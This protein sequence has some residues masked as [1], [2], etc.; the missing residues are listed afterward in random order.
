MSRRLLAAVLILLVELCLP[1]RPALARCVLARLA[2]LPVSLKH[3]RP[4][5]SLSL[6]GRET[7]FLIWND[8]FYSLLPPE[9]ASELKLRLDQPQDQFFV[10]GII[11]P[12]S[13]RMATVKTVGVGGLTIRNAQFLVRTVDSGK[14]GGLGQNF[15]DTGDG[16]EYDFGHGMLRLWRER[17]CGPDAHP[18]WARAGEPYSV[19]HLDQNSLRSGMWWDSRP[20]RRT[21]AFVNGTR[22]RVLIDTGSPVSLL[23]PLAAREAGVSLEGSAVTRGGAAPEVG[24]DRTWIAPFASFKIGDEELHDV[25]LRLGD[26][27]EYGVEM[28]LGADFFHSHRIYEVNRE[29]QLYFTY[30]GGNPVNID[31]RP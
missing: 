28:L 18:Y 11:D 27:K 9:V 7:P 13:W 21:I 2:E 17:D 3:G 1:D 29:H 16:I 23:S 6:E 5:V 20:F 4:V 22:I 15:L 10:R 30:N 31:A 14:M 8:S 26:L 25:R 24:V 19:V 12:S